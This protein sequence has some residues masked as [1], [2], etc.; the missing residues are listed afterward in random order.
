MRKR[1]DQ[2]S[3]FILHLRGPDQVVL[4]TPPVTKPTKEVVREEAID[5]I[6]DD[7]DVHRL[8][9]PKPVRGT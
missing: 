4:L 5:W 2:V 7:V 9:Y 6:S 8:L 3:L 1:T